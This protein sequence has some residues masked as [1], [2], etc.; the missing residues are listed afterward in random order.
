M[1]LPNFLKN[2]MKLE[3]FGWGA[4]PPPLD[5]PLPSEG[6]GNRSTVN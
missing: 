2:C 6:K 4:A 3:E 1:I 5:L